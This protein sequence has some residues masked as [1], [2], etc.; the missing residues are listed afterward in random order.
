M[1]PPSCLATTIV[2]AVPIITVPDNAPPVEGYKA[3]LYLFL[4]GAADSYSMLAPTD[5]C[6]N[7][8]SQY[9][10]VRGDTAIS[11]S[12]L[13][14]ISA[15]NQPCNSF[16]YSSISCQY[17]QPHNSGRCCVDTKRWTVRTLNKDEYSSGAQR[18][19]QT[20]FA[21]NTHIQIT[22]TILA[23]DTGAGCVLG[24]IGDVLNAQAGKEVFHAYSIAGTPRI[25][26]GGPG[27]PRTA[28]V[29]SEGGI[30]SLNYLASIIYLQVNITSRRPMHMWHHQFTASPTRPR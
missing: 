23:Q 19:T 3:I 15:S 8:H 4:G 5:S 27:V 18:I 24:R 26:E 11:S 30:V 6:S 2:R 25:L 9:M 16:W 22:Q 21:H 28:D 10:S 14:A 1:Q 7:L 29:L 20:L 13:R 17:P 12:S